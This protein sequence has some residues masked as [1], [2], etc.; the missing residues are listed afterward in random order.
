M[1]RPFGRLSDR[2]TPVAAILTSGGC[3]LTAAALSMLRPDAYQQLFGIALFGGISV[4]I[5]IL[6]CHLQFRKHHAEK[7]LPVRMPLFPYLQ[8]IGIALLSAIL[9]TMALI[10]T[11]GLSWICGVPWVILISIA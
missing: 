10:S 4:W 2:G 5:I 8:I 9:I 1:L 7:D 6:L 11:G 3:V